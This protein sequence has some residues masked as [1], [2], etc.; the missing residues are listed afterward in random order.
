MRRCV[1]LQVKPLTG[2]VPQSIDCLV[3]CSS[4]CLFVLRFMPCVLFL[5]KLPDTSDLVARRMLMSFCDTPLMPCRKPALMVTQSKTHT[6]SPLISYKK[7]CFHCCFLSMCLCTA[8]NLLF[9][10]LSGWTGRHRP[11]HWFTRSLGATWG[12]EVK[13]NFHRDCALIFIWSNEDAGKYI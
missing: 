6:N 12:Q 1:K 5:Q 9:F 11:P 2:T 8:L 7:L 3:S 10:W 4:D 13:Q